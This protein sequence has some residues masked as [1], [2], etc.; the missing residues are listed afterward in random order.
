[1][2]AVRAV[3]RITGAQR[4]HRAD[5]AAFLPDAGVGRTVD[6]AVG[7]Q[8]EHEFL[9]RANQAEL[10]EGARQQLRVGRVP[11][12][13]GDDDLDPRRGHLEVVVLR[14]GAPCACT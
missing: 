7:G 12:G 13:L 14:H 2:T 10:R 4:E 5:G 6:Q 1:M 9:E 3:D 11:V 8:P